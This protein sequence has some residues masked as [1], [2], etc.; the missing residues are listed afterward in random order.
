MWGVPGR[1]VMPGGVTF[2]L[3]M[4]V[5]QLPGGGLWLHSPEVAFFEPT[6]TLLCTDLVFHVLDPANPGVAGGPSDPLSR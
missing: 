1:A 2:P 5:V 4:T 3:R 6:S